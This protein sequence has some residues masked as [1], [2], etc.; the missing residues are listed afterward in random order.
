[1]RIGV[2]GTLKSSDNVSTS[3]PSLVE[4]VTVPP[5]TLPPAK[6][7]LVWF[8]ASARLV[9]MASAA[10][11]KSPVRMVRRIMLSS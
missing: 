7:L 11:L 9:I 2:S 1:M 6:G 5:L 10:T 3:L 8:C 4:W